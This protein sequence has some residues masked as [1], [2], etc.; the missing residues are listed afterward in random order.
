MPDDQAKNVSEA[1]NK[2]SITP[3]NELQ[4]ALDEMARDISLIEPN[5]QD[6]GWWVNYLLE[7][8]EEANRRRRLDDFENMLD[9]LL[10]NL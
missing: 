4:D 7:K 9:S 2:K 6:W 10:R 1:L 8:L 3:E 5:P